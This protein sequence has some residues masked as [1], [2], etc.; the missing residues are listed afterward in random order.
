MLIKTTRLNDGTIEH[1][2]TALYYALQYVLMATIAVYF[3]SPEETQEA[4]RTYLGLPLIVMLGARF[5]GTMGARSAMAKAMKTGKV[6]VTG[7]AWNITNPMTYRIP[8]EAQGE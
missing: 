8:P 2:Y 1:R 6:E 4:L 3:L 5:L 7:T